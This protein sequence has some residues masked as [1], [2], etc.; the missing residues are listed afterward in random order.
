MGADQVGEKVMA[1]PREALKKSDAPNVMKES[2]EK[3]IAYDVKMHAHVEKD[4]H[5][6][7]LDAHLWRIRRSDL[8]LSRSRCS[9]AG[10]G[11]AP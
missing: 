11:S 5:G 6:V 1:M 7:L 3:I 10:G 9:S 2:G 4:Y 8:A